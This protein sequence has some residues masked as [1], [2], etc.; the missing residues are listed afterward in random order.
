M[1]LQINQIDIQNLELLDKWN[2]FVDESPEGTFYHKS[3]W[4][5]NNIGS[6]FK[7][8]QEYK[9]FYLSDTNKNWIAAFYIPTSKKFGINFIVMPHMTPFGGVMISPIIHKLTI[10]KKISN[11]KEI[12]E[13]FI[14]ELKKENLLYYS[15]SP[16]HTDIQ[17]FIWNKYITSVRY[18]YRVN[19]VDEKILWSNLQE[20]TS[21][22][23]GNKSNV[24][25][26]WGF[27]E[28][29]DTYF[30]LND[31]SFSS[32]NINNFDN[33]LTKKL[34]TELNK[35]NNC[36]IG[37]IFDENNKAIGGC[38]LA[39]DNKRAY[40]IMGGISRENNFGM[41][42]LLWQAL[43]YTKNILQLPVFDFEGS[44]IP[45]IEKYFRKFGG[46]LTPY[47]SLN[48]LLLTIK[49]HIK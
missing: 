43:L 11:I 18:T 39:Y 38:V 34:L 1:N 8:A 32:Q 4:L 26:K 16:E 30:E 42:Y 27:S 20:K 24:T 12:N 29:L 19:L 5:L 47:Y 44:M 6:S 36:I 15:F 23:K 13:I 14:K 21:V 28:Y 17:P 9:F 7:S 40:Y 35:N 2:K 45:S 22:N 10:S 33:M 41:S 46:E 25:V 48:S 3:Y 31:K 49:N 37:I